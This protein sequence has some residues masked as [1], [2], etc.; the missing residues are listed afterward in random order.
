MVLHAYTLA[1]FIT[2]TPGLISKYLNLLTS[3][4]LEGGQLA[5]VGEYASWVKHVACARV[6]HGQFA[7][8]WTVQYVTMLRAAL[9]DNEA[10]WRAAEAGTA[11]ATTCGGGEGGGGEGG[12]GGGLADGMVSLDQSA[13]V[14]SA[15]SALA[16]R[17]QVSHRE[18]Y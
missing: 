12:G 3:L 4:R 10:S 8:G 6:L 18:S 7:A 11:L 2:M 14:L 17:A 15:L 9:V 16:H 13:S 1:H 5:D